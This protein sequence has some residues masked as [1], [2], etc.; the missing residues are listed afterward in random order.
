MDSTREVPMYG[1]QFANNSTAACQKQNKALYNIFED[2]ENNISL[3][4]NQL[5]HIKIISNCNKINPNEKNFMYIIN[6]TA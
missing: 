6:T 4:Y 1:R 2:Y 5:S 3:T